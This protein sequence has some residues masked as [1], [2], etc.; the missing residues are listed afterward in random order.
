MLPRATGHSFVVA[1]K[2][3]SINY[4]SFVEIV[5]HFTTILMLIIESLDEFCYTLIC[6]TGL[7]SFDVGIFTSYVRR[8]EAN[9]RFQKL[10]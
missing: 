3:L 7:I 2:K 8:S 10:A 6:N 5:A 4:K 1:A 9:V